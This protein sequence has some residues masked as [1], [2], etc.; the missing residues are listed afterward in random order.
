MA[1]TKKIFSRTVT[2]E[3]WTATRDL[4]HSI[5][6][7]CKGCDRQTKFL[8]ISDAAKFLGISMRGLFCLIEIDLVHSHETGSGIFMICRESMEKIDKGAW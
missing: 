3:R 5:S 8:P 6:G 7:F 4:H 2:F 1:I